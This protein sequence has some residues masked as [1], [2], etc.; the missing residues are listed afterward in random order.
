[1][2]TWN[3]TLLIPVRMPIMSGKL[4]LSVMDLDGVHDEQAGALIFD[5]KDL[6]SREQKSFF[7]ANIY[8]APGGEGLMA[9]GGNLADEMNKNPQ[10]ATK[11]KGRILIGIEYEETEAPKLGVERMSTVPPNDENGAP[12]G[13]SIVQ[14]SV[15]A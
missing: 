5:F 8:G 2:A 9:K 4:I 3:E 6:L 11:W 7:W 10:I 12:I 14:E 15:E 1:M 13:K